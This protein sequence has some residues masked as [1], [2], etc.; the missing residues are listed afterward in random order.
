MKNSYWF[1]FYCCF[2]LGWQS[3]NYAFSLG[4]IAI[5]QPILKIMSWNSAYIYDWI[6]ILWSKIRNHIFNMKSLWHHYDVIF[7]KL[8]K[9]QASSAK[10]HIFIESVSQVILFLVETS[11][12]A[13]L[14]PICVKR[15]KYLK[16]SWK[17]GPYLS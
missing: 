2:C 14:F 1:V 6:L 15:A 10:I 4:H 13:R 3:K 12:I 11:L 7:E 8:L 5:A 16:D 9:R 17:M